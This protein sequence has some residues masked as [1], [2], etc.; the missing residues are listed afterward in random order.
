MRDTCVVAQE[1]RFTHQISPRLRVSRVRT[2]IEHHAGE[3]AV[4]ETVK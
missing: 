3:E 4:P 1:Q 2:S